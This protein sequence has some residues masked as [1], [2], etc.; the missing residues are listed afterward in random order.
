MKLLAIDG[1]SILNRSFYGVKLLSNKNG[2]YTNALVGFLN[3]LL[4][5]IHDLQPDEIVVAF[6]LHAPTFRHKMYADYKGTRKGMPEELREQMPIAKQ[7]ITMLGYSVLELEGYE[8]DDIVGTLSRICCD[9]GNECVIASGDRDCLQLITDCVTVRLATTKEAISYTP[10]RYR[11]EYGIEPIQL[12]DVKAL[13][14]DSSDNIPGVKGIGEK[15]AYSLISR[16]ESLEAI[17]DQLEELEVT[18]R[19]KKLLAEGKESAFLSKDLATIRLD[20]PISHD[21]ASY[22]KKAVDHVGLCGLFNRLEMYS[23]IQKFQLQETDE[24]MTE[25]ISKSQT[26]MQLSKNPDYQQVIEQLNQQT[27]LDFL[28]VFDQETI[29]SLQICTDTTIYVFDSNIEQAFRQLILS[30]S[31]PK[32]TNDVKRLYRY[33]LPLG[34][35][36]EGVIFDVMIA[37]YLLDAAGR[38]YEISLLAKKYE[39]SPIAVAEEYQDIAYL[40]ELCDKLHK[41]LAAVGMLSLMSEI[42]MPLSLVLASMETEGFAVDVEGVNRFGSALHSQIEQI[43][44][45]MFEMIGYTFNPNS[46][47]DLK[48]I[49]FVH[50]GLTPKKKTKSGYSTDA[51]TL[52]SI[53]HEHEFVPL[54]L[55]Y[56]KLTKLYSTYVTGLLKLV[57]SNHRVHSTF[58]QTETRTGRISSTEP[59]MQ[60]IPTRTDLG[61]EM[62]KFFIAKEGY[63]LIDADYSQI[64][65]RILAHLSDDQRMIDAFNHDADIHST[66][67]SE[68]FNVPLEMVTSEMRTRAKAINFGIVYGIGAFSLSQDIGV[69]VAQASHYI[70]DYLS[71]YHGVDTFM[72]HTV[73]TAKQ[74]GYVSTMFGR[75]RIL[76]ELKS[77]N[78]NIRNFG[79]RAAMNAPI[80]GSAADIIKIAMIKVYQRMKK[81]KIDGKLILQVHDELILEVAEKDADRAKE[82]LKEEMERAAELKVKLTVD[83]SVGKT[84][85]DA[86][87]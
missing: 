5:M 16:Y 52:E 79:E 51:E 23:F 12:I 56:R 8:A 42:E 26:G 58:K 45:A 24:G 87:E 15:T 73:E 86:K 77:H 74:N 20:I 59:N 78:K 4:K 25:Q 70:N 9:T 17:Y 53:K 21:L 1:N 60:N 18:P 41:E 32:R 6:D 29:S 84:W 37:A 10:Q 63:Y 65:L 66:T 71:T 35:E 62:R 75:R 2:I 27:T 7:I 36:L 28:V 48:Q 46:T 11:E 68:V 22:E 57:D 83:V 19:I 39:V 67:A 50:L 30:S 54:L 49:L 80:Q 81:E 13:M 47:N 44:T 55:E 69:T 76:D 33:L 72:K 38:S 40:P 64:E 82:L 43:K 3:I 14:G 31:L 34:I 85:Y 61:R